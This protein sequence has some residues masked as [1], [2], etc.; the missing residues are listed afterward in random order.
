M[1]TA[2]DYVEG[3]DERDEFDDAFSEGQSDAE[4]PDIGIRNDY[5]RGTPGWHGYNSGVKAAGQADTP[6]EVAQAQYDAQWPTLFDPM[7]FF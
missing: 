2:A 5:E 4:Y 7:Q 1:K 6:N 3:S